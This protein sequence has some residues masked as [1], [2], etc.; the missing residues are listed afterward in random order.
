MLHSP[1]EMLTAERL[2]QR[3]WARRTPPMEFGALTALAHAGS[4]V[5]GAFVP[6]GSDRSDELVGCSVGFF[7]PPAERSLHSHITGVAPGLAGRGIGMAI[8]THQR[9]W[10]LER[11]VVV[12]TW[13]F[14]PAIAR[15]AYFNLAKLGV[16]VVGYLEDFYGAMDDGLN[17]GSPSDRLLVR[18]DLERAEPAPV[19]A[20]P[21]PQRT[22]PTAG[23][24]EPVAAV[25][26]TVAEDGSPRVQPVSAS[27]E[28]ALVAVPADMEGLRRSDPALAAAWR[29]AV[30]EALGGRL[31][32]GGWRV[33]RFLASGHYL[34][35]R[36]A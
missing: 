26:L 24:P 19:R 16:D 6:G 15:N 8:K 23:A 34:L 30:R 11:G 21:A 18:W 13:T 29:L 17:V 3:V 28:S 36:T 27:T 12:M 14:D 22:E 5:A 31:D 32:T 9:D 33:T 2:L 25:A 20:E 10:C 1:A 35:R 4:Y 7:G